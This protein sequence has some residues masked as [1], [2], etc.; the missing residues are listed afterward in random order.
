MRG[1]LG[2]ESLSGEGFLQAKGQL[3]WWSRVEVAK[4]WGHGSAV[5]QGFWR[6]L[7]RVVWV[8]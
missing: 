6:V 4:S 3:D 2:E 8:L 5:I 7:R 1:D